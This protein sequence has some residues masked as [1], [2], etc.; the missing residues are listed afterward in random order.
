ME[1][2]TKKNQLLQKLAEIEK[3]EKQQASSNAAVGAQPPLNVKLNTE[4]DDEEVEQSSKIHKAQNKGQSSEE[5]SMSAASWMELSEK[6]KFRP[7]QRRK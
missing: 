4:S 5:S 6:R 1:Q 2:V 7:I 3:L